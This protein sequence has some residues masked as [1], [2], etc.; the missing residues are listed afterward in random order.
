MADSH[1][2]ILT[3]FM[4]LS[5]T[6]LNPEQRVQC[7]LPIRTG[8]CG[9][10]GTALLQ[11][12]ARISAV[13]G[14]LSA[15][16]RRVG[17]PAFA[18]TSEMTDTASVLEDLRSRLGPNFDPLAQW[19]CN[20]SLVSTADAAHCAQSW[21]SAALGKSTLNHLIENARP[22]NQARM[23]EKRGGLGTTWMTALPSRGSA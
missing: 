5:G 20:P 17:A 6:A 12:A 22:R 23:L 21:W 16:G 19:T 7:T 3:A 9:V 15:G 14:F 4:T 11:P 1:E 13:A 2:A 10:K 18:L 8:G